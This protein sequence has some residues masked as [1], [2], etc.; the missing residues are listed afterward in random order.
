MVWHG[1]RL[2]GKVNFLSG[3]TL[4]QKGSFPRKVFFV[5]C[6]VLPVGVFVVAAIALSF[7]QKVIVR[8]DEDRRECRFTQQ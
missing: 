2:T 8:W 4:W 1:I 7:G 3:K 6:V 5:V